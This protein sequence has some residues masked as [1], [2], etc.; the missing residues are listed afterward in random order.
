[1]TKQELDKVRDLLRESPEFTEESKELLERALR[2]YCIW[3]EALGRLTDT[4]S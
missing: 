1:M 2:L 4:D 3:L